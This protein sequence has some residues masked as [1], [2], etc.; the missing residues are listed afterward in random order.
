MS[1]TTSLLAV[2]AAAAGFDSV[3][4]YLKSFFKPKTSKKTSS[5][6]GKTTRRGDKTASKIPSKYSSKAISKEMA[7]YSYTRTAT[8]KRKN[9]KKKAYSKRKKYASK[10]FV[11]ALNKATVKTSPYYISSSDNYRSVI[12]G[13][14]SVAG[15]SNLVSVD[16]GMAR[17][18]SGGAAGIWNNAQDDIAFAVENST[19]GVVTDNAL[20]KRYANDV[21]ID[22]LDTTVC[23]RNN[24]NIGV[25]V[26]VYYAKRKPNFSNDATGTGQTFEEII[27]DAMN[28]SYN[29][30]ATG[31][32]TSL[33][34]SESLY[35]YPIL[36]G[37][38]TLKRV[39]KFILYP[40]MTKFFKLRT[41]IAGKTF[42]VN[43]AL[44]RALDPRW[45]RG[46]VFVYKGLPVHSSATPAFAVGDVAYG[47][48]KV[49]ML[50]SRI[51]KYRV[52]PQNNIDDAHVIGVTRINSIAPNLQEIQPAVNPI[53]APV[54]S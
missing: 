13:N 50:I 44:N 35:D 42:K 9:K 48:W 25:S 43:N 36:C 20:A 47:V 53:N 15:N 45:H 11:R 22:R 10:R 4:E 41:P 18:T 5:S 12:N 38:I 14:T 52:I 26:E 39:R 54:D 7:G 1:K 32:E 34:Y 6:I 49:D 33:G 37:K 23:L 16:C 46:L 31:S 21:C 27:I 28:N 40:A 30:P 51:V 24:T 2:T 29:P 19:Q 3:K 17:W 8:K